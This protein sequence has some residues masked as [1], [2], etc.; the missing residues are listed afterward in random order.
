M[1]KTSHSNQNVPSRN[2]DFTHRFLQQESIPIVRSDMGG[3]CARQV[4]FFTDTGR[5]LLKRI[6]T[7]GGFEKTRAVNLEGVEDIFLSSLAPESLLEVL[8]TSA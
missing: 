7:H 5:V 1:L 2:I 8:T 6:H 3:H 4:H